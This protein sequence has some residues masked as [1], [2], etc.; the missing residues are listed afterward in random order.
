MLTLSRFLATVSSKGDTPC[1]RLAMHRHA[2]TICLALILMVTRGVAVAAPLALLDR[3][4]SHVSIEAYAPN[5]VRVTLSIDKDLALAPPGF[6]ITAAADATGWKHRVLPSGEEFSSDLMSLEVKAQPWPNPPS[7]MER[8]F[9][10]SLPPV[11]LTV[12]TPGGKP[13]LQMSG[14]EMAPHM[15]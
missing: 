11:S 5:I 1:A 4:G 9:A 8:Y 7:Q 2:F 6:G 14:W 12:R 13:I 10:P 15:V 3:N